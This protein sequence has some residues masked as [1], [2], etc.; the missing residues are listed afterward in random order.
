[1]KVQG[2]PPNAAWAFG[3]G[4]LPA[5]ATFDFLLPVGPD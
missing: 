2:G 4:I 5:V 3:T 1:M